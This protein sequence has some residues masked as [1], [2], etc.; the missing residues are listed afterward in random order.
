MMLDFRVSADKKVLNTAL[1]D[2]AG[3]KAKLRAAEA[4]HM[5]EVDQQQL[6][7]ARQVRSL[8]HC[9]AGTHCTGPFEESCF[10]LQTTV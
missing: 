10:K 1:A 6:K 3:L 8:H 2:I 7:S 5:H 4:A 9:H